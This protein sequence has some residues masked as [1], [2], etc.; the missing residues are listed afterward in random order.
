MREIKFR[1]FNGIEMEYKIM[2]GF[3]GSFYVPGLDE[4]DSASLS[5]NSSKYH[6]N[7][8]TMQFIGLKDG[9]GNDI[10]EGDVFQYKQHKNYLMGDFKGIV[11]W[12]NDLSCFGYQRSG[13]TKAWIMPFANHDELQ[14]DVLNHCEVIGNIYMNP[15][16]I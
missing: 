1:I 13:E 11:M 6:E 14:E 15:N 2:A 10:Y 3:L 12:N 4:N 7:T 16:L 9:A 5:P 8:P